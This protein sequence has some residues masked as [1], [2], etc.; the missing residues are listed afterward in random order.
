MSFLEPRHFKMM[1]GFT[2]IRN[3]IRIKDGECCQISN[4]YSQYKI[5]SILLKLDKE[6]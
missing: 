6:Y 2:Q 3:S 5:V 4:N 1:S